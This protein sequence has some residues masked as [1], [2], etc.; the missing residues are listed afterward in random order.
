MLIMYKVVF[1]SLWPCMTICLVDLSKIVTLFSS[2]T[3]IQL[4]SKSVPI[5]LRGFCR[6]GNLCAWRALSGRLCWGSSVIWDDVMI[7]PFVILIGIGWVA[8]CLFV[9]GVVGVI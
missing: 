4:L 3:A 8:V 5:D 2:K 9:H 6:P 7:S 1:G